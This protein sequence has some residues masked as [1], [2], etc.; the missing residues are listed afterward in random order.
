MLPRWCRVCGARGAPRRSF[1]SPAPAPTIAPMTGIPRAGGQAVVQTLAAAGIRFAFTV[2]G[3]SFLGVLDAL[4][5]A[6]LRTI[7]TRHEGGA[8]F[9][10]AAVGQL[11]G[12]P[13][14]CL[15]TRAV[16]AAN[17]ALALHTARQDS[18]P[19]IA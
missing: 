6:P 4:H 14:V 19:P 15:A 18:T 9:M 3:E 5:D 13:P 7:A 2:P 17:L 12:R 8:G 11:T 10:A 1:A 16:G